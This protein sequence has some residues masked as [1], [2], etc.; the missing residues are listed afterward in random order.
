MMNA[1]GSAQKGI[2]ILTHSDMDEITRFRRLCNGRRV[3]SQ[4]EEFLAEEFFGKDRD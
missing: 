3:K 1:E 2:I 4:F